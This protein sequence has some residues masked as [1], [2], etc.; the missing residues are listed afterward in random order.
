MDFQ[1]PS[2]SKILVPAGKPLARFPIVDDGNFTGHIYSNRRFRN[3]TAAEV[4]DSPKGIA[5]GWRRDDGENLLA[6]G[7][8]FGGI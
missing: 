1:E 3:R 6:T 7:D 5:G 4:P 8:F 2:A